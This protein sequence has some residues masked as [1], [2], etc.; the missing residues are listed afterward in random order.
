[1]NLLDF[2]S[3]IV[4]SDSDRV[5]TDSF[6]SEEITIFNILNGSFRTEDII[7]IR[8]DKASKI[9]SVDISSEDIARNAEFNLDKQIV[10]GSYVPLYRVNVTRNNK[11]LYFKLD[12]V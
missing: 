12:E 7:S 2:L 4:S 6:F 1:M 8:V 11:T 5:E 9:V 3:K 10:P